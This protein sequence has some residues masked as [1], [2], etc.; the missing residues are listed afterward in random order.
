MRI[1][2]VD[3]SRFMRSFIIKRLSE[4]GYTDFLEAENGQ[5]AAEMYKMLRPNMVLMDL[6]M[7]E[8]DG[9]GAL[10]KIISTNPGAKVIMCTSMG[11]Q[12]WIADE[13]IQH[14]AAQ[15]I[16]KPY[17]H[18]LI[19]IVNRVKGELNEEAALFCKENVF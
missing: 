8:L 11:G 16:E 9:L 1:L 4:A 15:V 17:F 3:D 18:N 7:P 5:K 12:K 14:G 10:K 13:L 19:E 2:V 6:N